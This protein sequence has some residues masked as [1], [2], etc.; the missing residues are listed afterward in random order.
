NVI[1]RDTVIHSLDKLSTLQALFE[2][3][4][5]PNEAQTLFFDAKTW[6][7]GDQDT[8]NDK[9]RTKFFI[10]TRTDLALTAMIDPVKDSLYL[11]GDT[12]SPKVNVLNTGN[13]TIPATAQL[14]YSISNST[15]SVVYYDSTTLANALAV[16]ASRHV[17][18]SPFVFYN[19]KD[20]YSATCFIRLAIDGEQANDTLRTN[21]NA[22]VNNSISLI[23]IKSPTQNQ[24]YQ[25][26]RD[27]VFP[28]FSL[29]N[30]GLKDISNPVYYT[31]K[32]KKGGTEVHTIYD[33]I[34]SFLSETF[35]SITPI[36]FI[37]TTT[38][39]YKMTVEIQN[40]DDEIT[41]DNSLEQDFF[42][43]LQNDVAPI[44]FVYPEIDSLVF[45]NR[46]Y[47]PKGRFKNLGDSAQSIEFSVSFLIS[48][49]GANRYNSNKNTTLD[50]GQTL[51]VSFDSTFEPTLPGIYQ[52]LL[53]SRLGNDQVT[54]ND[55]ILGS[56]VVDF[57]SSVS[58]LQ[59]FSIK[60]FPNPASDEISIQGLDKLI[61]SIGI[62]DAA[63]K[64][65]STTANSE[66]STIKID[67][68]DYKS[69]FYWLQIL[70]EDN[71][72]WHKII[73]D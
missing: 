11:L 13:G 71:T 19:I 54:S 27:T 18:F 43:S 41:T 44:A 73:I 52:M 53:I 12:I 6:I 63:G 10:K 61:S 23:E 60:V 32:I 69:G 51:V 24:V 22:S 17:T 2:E 30:T 40:V 47:A 57:H 66:Y 64:H 34:N 46:T 67:I 38:G 15:G 42:V 36:R 58:D 1:Y 29:A 26:N 39:G 37:P 28:S 55:T 70:V 9:V 25:L 65:V 8:T 62:Y 4:K 50:S 7:A 72:L 68:S 21:F 33:S 59:M 31:V 56:F 49:D 48:F 16:D 35:L 14:F 45:A 20:A 5:A 3:F